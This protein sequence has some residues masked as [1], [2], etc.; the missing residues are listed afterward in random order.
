VNTTPAPQFGVYF[1]QL[2]ASHT[3][4]ELRVLAAEE[5][6]FDSAWFLDHLSAPGLPEADCYEAWSVVSFLAARTSRIRLGHLVLCDAFRP[7]PLLAKMAATL[8]VLSGGRLELGI[9]WGSVQDELRAWG[10]GELPPAERAR[11]LVETLTV[12]R[13]LWSGEPVTWNGEQVQL[14]GV[15]C[16]PRPVDGQ[17]PIHIGGAG[18]KL[19]MPIVAEHADWWNCPSY[20]MDRWQELRPL[21]GP[22]VRVSTQRPVALVHSEARREEIAG[23][24]QRRFKAWGGLV[25]ANPDELAVLMTAERAQGVDMWIL[26]FSDFGQPETLELF[27]REVAPALS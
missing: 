10:F 25:V 8:D 11:R 16:R 5:K 12:L 17:I 13:L 2:N 4:L 7:A 15:S 27:M 20:A 22:R 24:A 1:P 18:P 21:A 26:Q 3:D 9:G 6:G 14:D 19:T 23:V